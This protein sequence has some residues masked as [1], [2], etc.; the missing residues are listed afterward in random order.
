MT[1]FCSICLL[2]LLISARRKSIDNTILYFKTHWENCRVTRRECPLTESNPVPARFKFSGT[3]FRRGTNCLRADVS[4]FLWCTRKRDL[5][6]VQGTFFACN[7]GNRRR[8]HAGKGTKEA[9]RGGGKL[10][11]GRMSAMAFP[12]FPHPL[13]SL[14]LSRAALALLLATPPNGELQATASPRQVSKCRLIIK[15]EPVRLAF[16]NH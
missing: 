4:Y 14:L 13:Y 10:S 2:F 8:L 1:S 11:P 7:K 15:I 9:A 12:F 5:F 3:S 16:V 6:R